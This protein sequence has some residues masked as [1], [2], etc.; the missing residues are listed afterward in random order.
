MHPNRTRNR[1][2]PAARAREA[3]SAAEA[4][5]GGGPVGEFFAVLGA[6]WRLTGAQRARLTPAVA[7][8]LNAG[9]T[10]QALAAFTGA[11]TSGVRN[12]YAVL[13]A[14]LSSAELPPPYTQ[15]PSPAA[16]VR[17]MRPSHPD[18][19]LRRR[20]TSPVPAL[21]ASGGEARRPRRKRPF[22]LMPSAIFSGLVPTPAT[23][24]GVPPEWIPRSLADGG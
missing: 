15:R 11:N 17:R 12:P 16:L 7:T 5:D 22:W 6:D 18:A 20:R 1:R 2:K 19:R 4:A 9:W 10:Q 3:P 13:A 23:S 24:V 8:A 21:Q 14:R